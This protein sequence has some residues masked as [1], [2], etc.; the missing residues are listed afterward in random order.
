[1]LKR[2][3]IECVMKKPTGKGENMKRALAVCFC[4]WVE[5]VSLIWLLRVIFTSEE[6]TSTVL[7]AGM[8]AGLVSLAI[9]MIIKFWIRS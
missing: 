3:Q 8:A 4:F 5:A 7:F 9:T 6:F 1:M 2:P